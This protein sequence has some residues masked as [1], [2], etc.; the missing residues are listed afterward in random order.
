MP[1]QIAPVQI[2]LV[3]SKSRLT[4]GLAC[5][6]FLLPLGQAMRQAQAAPLPPLAAPGQL[7]TIPSDGTVLLKWSQV[8]GA[9]AYRVFYAADAN[10][11]YVQAAEV[12]GTRYLVHGLTNW[13]PHYYVVAAVRR[14]QAG[15]RSSSACGT[16]DGP[17]RKPQGLLA[18]SGHTQASL[19]W[20]PVPGADSYVV[21]R[22][23]GADPKATDVPIATGISSCVW[24]DTGLTDGTSYHYRVAARISPEM[25]AS[26]VAQSTRLSPLTSPVSSAAAITPV[27][28]LLLAPASLT[29]VAG[30]GRV[31]LTWPGTA[32][33]ASTA[34][35]GITYRVYRGT[36]S[37]GE[38]SKP[39]STGLPAPSLS[40]E[41]MKNGIKYYYFVTAV[42]AAGESAF[43]PERSA[44]PDVLGV[45]V[46][47]TGR[48]GS[49]L[50]TLNMPPLPGGLVAGGPGGGSTGN[51]S[52]GSSN[53]SAGA[54]N[55]RSS[56]APG[57]APTGP[58]PTKPAPVQPAP[59][60]ASPAPSPGGGGGGGTVPVGAGGASSP[61]SGGGVGHPA[62]ADTSP[63]SPGGDV[64]EP[65]TPAD[66]PFYVVLSSHQVQLVP[67]QTT[68]VTVTFASA[69][70]GLGHIYPSVGTLPPQVSA[71]FYPALPML[72][73]VV[74]G[75]TVATATLYLTCTSGSA[76]ALNVPLKATLNGTL[77]ATQPLGVSVSA[78][79]AN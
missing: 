79:G 78:H 34:P 9:G 39:V 43:S 27:S 62:N 65:P 6:L 58:A 51:P 31:S 4:Q 77:F 21:Y 50:G 72:V 68:T 45:A 75:H 44:T 30:N 33:L 42:N 46:A 7:S 73:T 10:G 24:T 29:A 15:S 71:F 49:G 76:A 23:K 16:P 25:Q 63:G 37:G 22:T 1:S 54:G 74:D 2:A 57:S 12:Q 48:A 52:A 36:R 38:G 13:V 70:G 69:T 32:R 5:A 20:E 60:T 11:P 47:S 40:A 66:A 35:T 28:G 17:L 3:W 64:P 19:T 59:P 26:L 56:A 67:G 55:G 41:G 8:A 18:H 14:G 61:V 53:P